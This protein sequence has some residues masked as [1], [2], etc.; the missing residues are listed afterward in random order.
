MWCYKL[1][2]IFCTKKTD[3]SQYLNFYFE[4]DRLRS[5]KNWPHDFVSDI[6][7]AKTG[8]YYVGKKD[9]VKCKFCDVIIHKWIKGD[10][11]VTEHLKWSPCCPLLCHKTTYN[12]PIPSLEHFLPSYDVTGIFKDILE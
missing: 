11:E 8:F 5:F 6:V 12:V 2:K 4:K 10:D 1:K 3:K 7:L 9:E